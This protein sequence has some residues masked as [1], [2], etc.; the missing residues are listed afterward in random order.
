MQQ[1]AS[2]QQSYFTVGEAARVLNVS[3]DTIRRMDATGVVSLTRI[4]EQR[5][6]TADDIRKIAA[7]RAIAGR[8]R[9]SH[10]PFA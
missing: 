2:F 4:G 5:V 9:K 1:V 8:K 6:L 3:T 10:A 7:H